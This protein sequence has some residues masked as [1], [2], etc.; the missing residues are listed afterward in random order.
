M[1]VL[2]RSPRLLPVVLPLGASECAAELVGVVEDPDDLTG[3]VEDPD[4]LI[5][6]IDDCS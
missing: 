5:G 1:I 6:V 2:I 4:D 3:V